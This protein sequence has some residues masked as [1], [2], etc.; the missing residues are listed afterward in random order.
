MKC[1][2]IVS[3]NAIERYRIVLAKLFRNL[4]SNILNRIKCITRNYYGLVN[5][6]NTKQNKKTS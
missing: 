2:L 1:V 3:I 5:S 4:E 6:E